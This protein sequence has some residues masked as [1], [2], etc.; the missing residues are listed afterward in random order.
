MR[1]PTPP[2]EREVRRRALAVVR[3]LR[4]QKTAGGRAKVSE[5][6]RR[7][8]A[9]R[10]EAIEIEED[11]LDVVEIDGELNINLRSF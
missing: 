8:R 9:R 6:Q 3:Q 10:N 5:N 11:V 7:Y 2:E 1:D 4:Y